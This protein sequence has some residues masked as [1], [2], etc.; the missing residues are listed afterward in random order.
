[1]D[2]ISNKIWI[3]A[4]KIG[5]SSFKTGIE[6]TKSILDYNDK[7]I[8][9]IVGFAITTITLIISNNDKLLKITSSRNINSAVI[10]LALSFFLGI[11]YRL[12]SFVLIRYLSEIVIFAEIAF[13]TDIEF[14]AS[15]DDYIKIVNDSSDY[16]FI[17]SQIKDA[18]GSI[19]EDLKESY[20][21][22]NDVEKLLLLKH[23]KVFYSE[24]VKHNKKHYDAAMDYVLDTF[25]KAYNMTDNEVNLIKNSGNSS[26]VTS[27]YYR[28]INAKLI[29]YSF[30]LSCIS[31]FIAIVIIIFSY[32][33]K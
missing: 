26:S 18:G 33:I 3:S 16:N 7:F 31:F 22:S 24:Q 30:F 14:P 20:N 28:L 32:L 5:L 6:T 11:I 9:W 4:K 27:K 2:E 13:S 1:M 21:T 23:I 29:P 8:V 19:P 15:D 10:F 17:L 12:L 25:K